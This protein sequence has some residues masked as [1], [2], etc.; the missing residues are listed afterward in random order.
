MGGEPL[1]NT[2]TFSEGARNFRNSGVLPLNA[3]TV[4]VQ[5][6]AF[7]EG[8]RAQLRSRLKAGLQRELFFDNLVVV[9]EDLRDSRQRD[10]T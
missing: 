2:H 4:C 10:L 3:P 7:V 8:D 1:F 9:V 5:L 6:L